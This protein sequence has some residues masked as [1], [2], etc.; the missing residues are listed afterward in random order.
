MATN[1]IQ[2][3]ARQSFLVGFLIALII[4]AVFVAILFV[5]ISS[6][7]EDLEATKKDIPKDTM[8]YV[9]MEDI[10]AGDKVTP[11]LFMQ[12]KVK[13][14]ADLSIYLNPDIFFEYDEEG[15]VFDYYAKVD[16]PFDSMVLTSTVV[17]SGTETRSDERL[18]EYNM[19]VLPTQL[20]NGDYIDI[21]FMLPT[22]E[23]YIVLSKKYVEQTTATSVWIKVTEEELLS[24]NSAIIDAYTIKGSKIHATM[25]TNPGIQEAAE[26]TYPVNDN[27]LNLMNSDSNIINEAKAELVKRWSVDSNS[28]NPETDYRDSRNNIDS[29]TNNMTNDAFAGQVQTNIAEEVNRLSTSRSE[30][31]SNLEG[32]GLVGIEL[33]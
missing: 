13:T 8:V 30:Y 7:N 5:K 27:I 21:R 18:I 28:Q 3:R 25:Y 31:V 6:L 29:Y 20:K 17:K 1:P 19:V 15:N 9:A 12:K 32:T 11:E 24:M 16:I 26:P 14:D 23:D 10:K 22:S 33:Y 4:M 2:R